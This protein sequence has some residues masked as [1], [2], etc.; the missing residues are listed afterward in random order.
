MKTGQVWSGMVGDVPVRIVYTRHFIDRFEKDEGD[1]PAVS[2]YFSDEE[3][4]NVI[5]DAAQ[6]ILD[7]WLRVWDFSGVVTSHA[8]DL[9][10][11]FQTETEKEGL[12][13]VMKNMMIKPVYHVRP[14][15][16]VFAVAGIQDPTLSAA[17][18]DHMAS[19]SGRC[20]RGK[21]ETPEAVYSVS[22]K[23]GRVMV[24]SACWKGRPFMLEI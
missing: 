8:R 13:I 14:E 2:R 16:Y 21:I 10:M 6:W 4:L 12:T 20:P 19:L 9:N 22:R 3:I 5:L 23:A 1:R 24:R 17:V 11:S 7:Q 15:D 18:A